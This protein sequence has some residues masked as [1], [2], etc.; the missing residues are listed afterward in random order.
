MS[1]GSALLATHTAGRR[2]AGAVARGSGCL[3]ALAL[4]QRVTLQQAVPLV[5]GGSGH[6]NRFAYAVP[7]HTSACTRHHRG[8]GAVAAGGGL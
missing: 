8:G 3:G 5:G 1:P 2:I 4:R 6:S 7:A